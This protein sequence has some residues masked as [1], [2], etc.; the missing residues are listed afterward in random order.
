MV[1]FALLATACGPSLP[2][3]TTVTPTAAAPAT[4]AP[5]TTVDAT[6]TSTAATLP[7]RQV[8][9]EGDL[10]PE[11]LAAV[12]G[13]YSWLADKRNPLP[14]AAVNLII[15]ADDV[16][17]AV[18]DSVTVTGVMRELDGGDTVAVAHV[19]ED[20]L[21][22]VKDDKPWRTVGTILDGQ[23]PWLGGTR[24][25]LVLG[26]DARHGENQRRLR[27][28]S[29]HIVGVDPQR[30]EGS[31]VGFPRDSW[32]QGPNG[33][34][35]FTNVM[36][37][38]GPEVMIETMENLTELELDGYVVTGFKGFEGLI[39]DLGNLTI[40]LP[41]AIKSGIEGWQ[42]YPS[43]LQKLGPT[44]LLR[45]ARIR[46]TLNG[47][48]FARSANH[49]LIMLAAMVMVQEMGI[50][51]VPELMDT[52]LEHAW[53]DL[54]TEDLLTMAATVFILTPEE[55]VNMVMPGSVGSAGT[56][57]VVYLGSSSADI[58]L[59]LADGVIDES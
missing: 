58:Y 18:A 12:A 37:R 40:D 11:A 45:L 26:S 31:I 17:H 47:G 32:V 5:N 36:A 38:R 52:L 6:T 41:R 56:Q 9:A 35:K 3:S 59:D 29:I 57:S 13:F 42:N 30:S 15:A 14:A 22:M 24:L 1:T 49:G 20:I 48:D 27:A 28:D 8:T 25:L 23:D 4:V 43:G 46:K 33:G 21:L 54:S 53:T 51:E 44:A 39:R 7:P 10:P 55:M 50:D 19:G 2:E 34:S 16:A